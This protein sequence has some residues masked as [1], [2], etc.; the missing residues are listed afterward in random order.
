MDLRAV[1]QEGDG[2]VVGQMVDLRIVGVEL[3]LELIV[4]HVD[5]EDL[6]L[7]A[8]HNIRIAGTG[9]APAQKAKNH[10][11]HQS[12]IPNSSLH[13]RFLLFPI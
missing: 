1:L 11:G 13:D 2:L 3:P 7:H 4:P 5:V 9:A 10:R 12:G 8:R 6:A